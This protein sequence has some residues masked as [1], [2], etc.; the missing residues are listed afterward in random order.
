LQP[1]T[2]SVVEICERLKTMAGVDSTMTVEEVIEKI[3]QLLA[4]APA[5]ILTASLEDAVGVEERPNMPATTSESNPNWSLALPEPIEDLMT[6]ELA[7]R[8]GRALGER[9]RAATTMQASEAS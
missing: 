7:G 4:K 8:I 9:V 1:N 6:G 5:R 2:E 3:Y